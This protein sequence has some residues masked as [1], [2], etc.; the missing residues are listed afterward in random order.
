MVG[1]KLLVRP[2]RPHVN[3]TVLHHC[4]FSVVRSFVVQYS[5]MLQQM[6]CQHAI[7]ARDL[8]RV[9]AMGT[10]ASG[11]LVSVKNLRKEK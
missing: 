1:C 8:S 9:P 2:S 10:H 11:V 7:V 3:I 6:K 4:A 5:P